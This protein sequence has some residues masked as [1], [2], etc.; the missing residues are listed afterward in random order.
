MLFL[1]DLSFLASCCW[2]FYSHPYTNVTPKVAAQTAKAPELHIG[3]IGTHYAELF[4][5]AEMFIGC[6]YRTEPKPTRASVDATLM[7]IRGSFF[8][9]TLLSKIF[10]LTIKKF[11]STHNA[12]PNLQTTTCF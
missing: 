4:P 12:T 2:M 11:K 6:F 10:K 8:P 3:D 1:P 9:Y 5:A 7:R